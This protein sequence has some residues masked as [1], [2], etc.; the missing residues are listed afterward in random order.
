[1]SDGEQK[2]SRLRFSPDAADISQATIKPLASIEPHAA[3]AFWHYYTENSN[4]VPSAFRC[5]SQKTGMSGIVG[6]IAV[7]ELFRCEPSVFPPRHFLA[8]TD[9][10]D[11]S[12]YRRARSSG[13]K[14]N[15]LAR[16]A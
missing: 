13:F 3:M 11:I 15:R 12:A 10:V 1:M 6:T 16:R 8:R 4:N 7:A 9:F 2:L 5:P 14:Y